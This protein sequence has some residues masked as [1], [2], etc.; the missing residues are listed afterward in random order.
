MKFD[1][2]KLKNYFIEKNY[3]GLDFSFTPPIDKADNA[4]SLHE[5][6]VL[7]YFNFGYNLNHRI[8]SK[9]I[10]IVTS[11]AFLIRD[12]NHNL[13]KFNFGKDYN[14]L[15][16]SNRRIKKE[17]NFMLSGKNKHLTINFDLA[18]VNNYLILNDK[19]FNPN[20][21]DYETSVGFVAS[22][23]L[24]LVISI[25]FIYINYSS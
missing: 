21:A 13:L 4:Q 5:T 16:G 8:K 24:F 1:N 10:E 15:Y 14:L 2:L 7:R 23:V 6:N 9:S 22:I 11:R 18:D 12:E 20:L 3:F 17:N 19:K 25:F